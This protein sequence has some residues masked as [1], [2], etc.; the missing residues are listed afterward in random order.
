MVTESHTGTHQTPGELDTDTRALTEKV[1]QLAWKS[2]EAR[3]RGR[4]V[5]AEQLG[6]LKALLIQEITSL[7]IA[8]ETNPK[9]LRARALEAIALSTD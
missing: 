2:L 8:G 3:R 6:R 5:S 9:V 7:A 4:H 1:F